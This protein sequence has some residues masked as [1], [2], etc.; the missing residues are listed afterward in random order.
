MSPTNSIYTELE[1]PDDQEEVP[2]FIADLEL[3]VINEHPKEH[4]KRQSII[5]Q[6]PKQLWTLLK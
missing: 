5:H 1:L 4:E 6:D 3:E 2:G